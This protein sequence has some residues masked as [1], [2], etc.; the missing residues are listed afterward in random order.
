MWFGRNA[1]SMKKYKV[2]YKVWKLWSFTLRKT[3][4]H[5]QYTSGCTLSHLYHSHTTYAL[6]CSVTR[7]KNAKTNLMVFPAMVTGEPGAERRP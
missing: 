2:L 1:R 5:S 3:Q 4:S 7:G 6:I